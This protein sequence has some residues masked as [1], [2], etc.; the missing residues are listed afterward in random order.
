[1]SRLVVQVPRKQVWRLPV[2]TVLLDTPEKPWVS[3]LQVNR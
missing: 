1:M 2:T 3:V